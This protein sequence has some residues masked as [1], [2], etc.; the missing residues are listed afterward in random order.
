[1]KT[2]GRKIKENGEVHVL[3]ERGFSYSINFDPKNDLLRAK[4]E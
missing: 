2:R 4:N 3:R 1:M